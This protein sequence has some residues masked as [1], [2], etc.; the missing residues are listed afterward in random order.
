MADNN[1][2]TLP[3][4][5]ANGRFGPGNPGRP[6]GSSNRMSRAVAEGILAHFEAE[7]TDI[8]VELSA[9]APGPRSGADVW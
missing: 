2:Q 3:A 9:P 8:S 1:P 6:F 7:T 5:H 4:R